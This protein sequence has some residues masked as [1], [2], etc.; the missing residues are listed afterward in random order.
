[1]TQHNAGTLQDRIDI[2]ESDGTDGLFVGTK[3]Y[4]LN[5]DR[6]SEN[7][8]FD[9]MEQGARNMAAESSNTK[10][11]QYALRAASNKL[12]GYPINPN[13]A[14]AMARDAIQTYLEAINRCRSGSLLADDVMEYAS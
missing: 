10:L 2:Y 3:K 8:Y 4:Y 9:I 13:D 14:L 7:Q 12:R 11:D 5:G 1:M 6:I